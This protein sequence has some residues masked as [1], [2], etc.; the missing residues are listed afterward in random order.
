MR[1]QLLAL[2]KQRGVHFW[3]ADVRHQ[4]AV[5]LHVRHDPERQDRPRHRRAWHLWPRR[6]ERGRHGSTR[7][8]VEVYDLGV[9]N[10]TTLTGLLGPV[11]SVVGMTAILNKTRK[12]DDKGEVQVMADENTMLIMDHGSGIL[13]HVQTGF[14]YFDDEIAPSR[15]RK[16]Y[17][18]NI[19]G[20]AGAL[21]LQGWDWEAC[22]GRCCHP[23]ARCPQAAMPREMALRLGRWGTVCCPVPPHRPEEPD[24]CRAWSACSG[25]H[26]R[27][28]R[29]TTNWAAHCSGIHVP[30]ASRVG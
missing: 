25:G 5:P 10:V 20:T 26:E 21:H 23:R 9:Y 28:S 17:T 13:S 19:M 14:V 1:T 11:K 4:S 29:V 24:N 27:V 16:L 2:A 7:K 6:T 30:M 18:V 3:V 15:E 8:E 12:V 22:R